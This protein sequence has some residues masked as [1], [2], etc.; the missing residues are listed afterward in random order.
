MITACADSE[1]TPP[2]QVKDSVAGSMADSVPPTALS[3][4]PLMQNTDSVQVIYYDNPDGD[5]LRYARYYKFTNATDSGFLSLVK[6]SLQQTVT[7]SYEVRNCRSIGK[8]YLFSKNEPVKTLYFSNREDGCRYLYFIQ[9]GNF[10][11]MELPANLENALIQKK[12]E[13][14]TP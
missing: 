11:Y 9:N 12:K 2:V 5:S 10:V 1:K 3:L 7:S 14:K 6:T 8:M 13:S 4:A